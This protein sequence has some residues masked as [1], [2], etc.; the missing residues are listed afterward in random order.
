MFYKGE[1]DIEFVN[2]DSDK[3]LLD[4]CKGLKNEE[5]IH[6][7]VIQ[8]INEPQIMVDVDENEPECGSNGSG[9]RVPLIEAYIGQTEAVGTYNG[10]ANVASQ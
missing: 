1:N 4:V 7:Y 6:L 5:E 3:V 9:P 8:N 10:R 2:V